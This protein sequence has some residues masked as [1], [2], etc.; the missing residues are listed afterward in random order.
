MNQ[1]AQLDTSG[2]PG[3]FPTWALVGI[4]MPNVLGVF[5]RYPDWR[6]WVHAVAAIGIA[7]TLG[8]RIG[9]RK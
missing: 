2:P 6:H 7:F 3:I 9:S 5:L 4:W 8:Q 1:G